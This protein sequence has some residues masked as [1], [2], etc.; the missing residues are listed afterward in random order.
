MDW[1]AATLCCGGPD[2][3]LRLTPGVAALWVVVSSL[4]LLPACASRAP[5]PIVDHSAR[6]SAP[7]ADVYKVLRGDTLY[8]IAFRYGLDYRRFAAAN[9]IPL[10][11][12]IFPGQTLRLREAELAQ[13]SAV[14]TPKVPASS[15]S[16]PRKPVSTKPAPVRTAPAIPTTEEKAAE[17]VSTPSPAG[18]VAVS[19]W[20]WPARGQ[21]KR[22]FESSL[23]KGI[24]IAGKRGDPVVASAAGRIV[25]AGSGIAGY[26][27]MLIVRHNDTYLSAYGHNDSLLVGE[28]DDVRSGETIARRGSSG[29]DSVKLHFEIR[30]GGRPVDPLQLLPHR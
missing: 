23:H 21:L 30:R 27:L 3:A 15:S 25:Y 10:P 1:A 28:G 9:R 22:R 6:S 11:Y 29:T 12:T 7:A 4:V 19:A 18:N 26:G 20:L 24:D 13:S 17:T 2:R 14:A 5:A 8:A 16:A